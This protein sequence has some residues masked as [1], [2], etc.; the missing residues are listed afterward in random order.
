MTLPDMMEK[1]RGPE[2]RKLFRYSVAS[3]VAVVIS[4]S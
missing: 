3:A 2:G 1:L 4:L